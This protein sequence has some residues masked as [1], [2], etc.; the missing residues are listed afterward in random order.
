[1]LTY[2]NTDLKLEVYSLDKSRWK[3]FED[4]LGEK[5]GCGGCWCMSWRLKK[6]DFEKNKGEVNKANMKSLVEQQEEI[7]VL[8]YIDG[9]PIGWCAVAP[10]ERFIKLQNSRVLK[11]IDD[12]PVWSITCIFLAKEYR[13]KELSSQLIMGAVNYCKLNNAKII[14]AYPAIPYDKKVPAAFLWTGIPVSY[15]RAGFVVATQRSKWKIIMRY[16]L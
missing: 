8:A 6:S 5:G 13:R 14:E 10:R 15:E 12:Q 3:D 11:R 4:L 2:E 9:K 7:G 1:M 16:Y